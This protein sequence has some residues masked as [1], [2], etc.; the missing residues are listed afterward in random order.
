[1]TNEEMME[2]IRQEN[3]FD[4]K[5]SEKLKKCPFCGESE[6]QVTQKRMFEEIKE[7]DIIP[8]PVISIRC[9]NCDCVKWNYSYDA[10]LA[11]EE[12]LE[13]AIKEWNERKA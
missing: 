9:K 7:E 8:A 3:E 2:I 5:V 1:M 13:T 6:F 11:Y 4:K 10:N 12:R